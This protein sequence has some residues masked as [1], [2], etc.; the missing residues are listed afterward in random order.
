ILG[1]TLLASVISAPQ[2]VT[3]GATETVRSLH[4]VR[5]FLS[6]PIM[7]LLFDAPLAPLYFAAG[8]LISPQLGVIA[9]IAGALLGGIAVFNPRA[10]SRPL[11]L[12]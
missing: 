12:A 4:H 10:T 2:G 7:L 3:G 6:S 9:L 11:G 1:G 8:F 5:N